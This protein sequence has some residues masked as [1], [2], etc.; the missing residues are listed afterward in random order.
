VAEV[1]DKRALISWC[2]YDWANSAFPTVIITFVFATYFTGSVAL[3]KI[4]GTAYWGYTMSL[5]ALAVAI[6]APVFGA[7]ADNLGRRKTWLGFFTALCI[8]ASCVLWFVEPDPSFALMALVTAGLANFAFETG[9]V[10]YNAMLPGLVRKSHLGRVSGWGWGLGYFGGLFCLAL[11]L[12]GLV[13]PESP[14]FGL[15]KETAEHVRATALLV[16]M[17]YAVFSI[18]LFLFTPDKIASDI[19]I[20]GAIKKG[21]SE[22]RATFSQVRQHSN[23]F[24]FLIARM[25]YTDGLNTLYAFGGIYAAGSFGMELNEIII[26]GIGINVTAGLGAAAFGWVDDWIGPKKTVMIA[27]AALTVLGT[28]LLIVETKTGFWTFGLPLGLF[29]GPAQAA[30][31][32]MMVRLAPPEQ[33]TETFGLY[34]LSG[35]ATAFLGPA[36]LGAASFAFDSQRAG[37]ATILVFFALGMFLLKNIGEPTVKS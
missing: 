7:I 23:M 13:Q 15:E 5:S 1:L 35:K 32:S 33:I 17:W 19:S 3:D 2:L 22:L 8:F 12:I 28:A 25:I 10:F 36:L 30:S 21:L 27:L 37:M 24:K 34:A 31:R 18:P 11:T 14:W 16:A 6:A 26:F 9:M 4:T 20:V 29:V